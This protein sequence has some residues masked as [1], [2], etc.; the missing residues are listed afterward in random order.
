MVTRDV[1]AASAPSTV[2]VSSQGVSEMVRSVTQIDPI[3]PSSAAST[4]GQR[5]FGG[6][7]RRQ[8]EAELGRAGCRR[9]DHRRPPRF[10]GS[11]W[12]RQG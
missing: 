2:I 9:V 12:C 3:P 10:A 11:P 6:H 5:C 1:R 7:R 4:A 8:D